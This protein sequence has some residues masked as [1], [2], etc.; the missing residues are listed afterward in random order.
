MLETS[1]LI[2]LSVGA[3]AGLSLTSVAALKG[4]EGWLELKRMEMGSDRGTPSP[5]ASP[6]RTE[7][8]ALKDR[9]R[10][11]EAIANGIDP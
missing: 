2:T 9:V 3:V 5:P 1:S 8:A 4:W 10:K 6:V 7:V 11:L